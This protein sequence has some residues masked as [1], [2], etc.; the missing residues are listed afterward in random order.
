MLRSGSELSH[1][2][3]SEAGVRAAGRRVGGSA[4]WL[5]GGAAG[6][7]RGRW[8]Q[9]GR[10]KGS[11]C[12]RCRGPVR[13]NLRRRGKGEEPLVAGRS[14]RYEGGEEGGGE[15]PL[16]YIKAERGKKVSL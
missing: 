7:V 15:P 3:R 10:H 12:E 13:Q 5:E 14:R 8:E 1:S 16:Q 11:D 4:G 6:Q 9:E 2:S